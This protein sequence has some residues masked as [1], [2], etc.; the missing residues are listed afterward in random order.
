MFFILW[1]I[2]VGLIAGWAAGRIMGTGGYGPLTDILLGIAGAIVGGFLLH[3]VGL[4]SS[5]G[6]H[7]CGHHGRGVPH[8]AKPQTQESLTTVPRRGVAPHH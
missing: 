8:L 4:Y 5:G 6:R 1:M 7:Y 2:V 3:L